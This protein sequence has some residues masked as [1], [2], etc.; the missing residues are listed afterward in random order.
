VAAA[1]FP[2]GA[3]SGD[4]HPPAGR[5]AGSGKRRRLSLGLG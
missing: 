1:A 5:N 3:A 2:S 4:C